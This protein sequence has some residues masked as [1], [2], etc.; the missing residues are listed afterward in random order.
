M[1]DLAVVELLYFSGDR[2]LVWDIFPFFLTYIS[3][4]F[5]RAID[6]IWNFF[7]PTVMLNLEKYEILFVPIKLSSPPPP[8]KKTKKKATKY[9]PSLHTGWSKVFQVWSLQFSYHYDSSIFLFVTIF[10]IILTFNQLSI[11]KVYISINLY[12]LT[13]MYYLTM[14]TAL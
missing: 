13:Y 14:F 8:L 3:L 1:V 2:T 9:H 4:I 7:S 5:L 11:M 10:V 12:I 6:T